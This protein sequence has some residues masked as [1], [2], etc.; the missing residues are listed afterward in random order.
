VLEQTIIDVEN[1][2]GSKSAK[3]RETLLEKALKSIIEYEQPEFYVDPT[4]DLVQEEIEEEQKKFHLKCV[5]ERKLKTLLASEIS[6]LALEENL[7]DIALDAGQN[8]VAAE[9]NPSKDTE[10]VI[11]QSE[12]HYVI[13][14]CYVE[15]LLEEEIEIGY[16]ELITCDED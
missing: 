11:S 1:A 13:A 7:I 6:K 4:R 12:A 15:Y 16:G 14:S 8:C 3:M 2:K 5:K 9:W 10:Q